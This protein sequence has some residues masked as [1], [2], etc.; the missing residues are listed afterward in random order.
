[1]RDSQTIGNSKTITQPLNN[2]HN[3]LIYVGSL[4]PK[5]QV[6]VHLWED[7]EEVDSTLCPFD[8]PLE[9]EF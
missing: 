3:R 7:G 6:V 5:Y 2:T 8:S 1:M 9:M 4:P